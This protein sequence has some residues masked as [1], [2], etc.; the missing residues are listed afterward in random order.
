M[1]YRGFELFGVLERA[2]GRALNEAEDVGRA[3]TQVAVDGVFRFLPREQAFVGARYNV[4]SGPLAGPAVAGQIAAAGQD[5]SIN[6]VEL[7]G[8][9]FPTRN[10]LLKGEY[11]RQRYTDFPTADIRNGG[12][13]SGFMVEGVVSF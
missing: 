10:I 3:W 9:W 6:R 12:E 13:F 4:V 5:I 1:K 2:T 11:V 8:G 7:G